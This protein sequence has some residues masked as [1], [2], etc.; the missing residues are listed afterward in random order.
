MKKLLVFCLLIIS[1]FSLYAEKLNVC[2]YPEN[3]EVKDYILESYSD[4]L[5]LITSNLEVKNVDLETGDVHLMDLI[6]NKA[7][8]SYIIIPINEKLDQFYYQKIY[9]YNFN[10]KSFDKIYENLSQDSSLFSRKAI[11]NLHSY[12]NIENKVRSEEVNKKTISLDLPE[13]DFNRQMD[14]SSYEKAKKD[15]YNSFART[16]A[17]FSANVLSSSFNNQ[18]LTYVSTGLIGLSL[19]DLVRSL[20]KYCNYVEYI[21]L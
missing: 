4:D 11:E 15:F 19:F 5:T 20:I 12:L 7:K 6:C 9:V 10:T 1:L 17:C 2:M 16:L 21:S 14:K 18:T 8:C 3:R 13:F